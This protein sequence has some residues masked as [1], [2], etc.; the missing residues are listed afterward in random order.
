MEGEWIKVTS[1]SAGFGLAA[2][3][4]GVSR[5]LGVDLLDGALLRI[6]MAC[7]RTRIVGSCEMSG[8]AAV[9]RQGYSGAPCRYIAITHKP[10][11]GTECQEAGV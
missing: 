10:T 5:A 8:V 9:S 6:V 7:V 3:P 2:W 4:L 1:I 11:S